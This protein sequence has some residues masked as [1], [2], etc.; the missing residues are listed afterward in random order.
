[1]VKNMKNEERE[2]EFLRGFAVL[3]AM[4]SMGR[5]VSP[6]VSLKAMLLQSVP[7]LTALIAPCIHIRRKAAPSE[8][9]FILGVFLMSNVVL[10]AVHLPSVVDM[11][12]WMMQVDMAFVTGLIVCSSSESLLQYTADVSRVQLAWFYFAAGFLK[13]TKYH[14]DW[15]LSCSSIFLSQIAIAWVPAQWMLP[16][17]VLL[18]IMKTAP[19]I[20]DILENGIA[21]LLFLGRSATLDVR[22]KKTTHV[23]WRTTS[24]HL[25]LLGA[26]AL[27]I[28][29]MIAPPPNS[30]ANFGAMCISC[31]FLCMPVAV[32]RA[33]SEVASAFQ[34]RSTTRNA[35]LV[36]AAV[37]IG[38]V[39]VTSAVHGDI[40]CII[41]NTTLTGFRALMMRAMHIERSG[42]VTLTESTTS[43]KTRAK[44]KRHTLQKNKRRWIDDARACSAVFFMSFAAFYAIGMPVLGL[45]DQGIS[46]MFGHLKVHAGSSHYILPTG[47][48]QRWLYDRSPLDASLGP[49]RDFAGGELRIEASTSDVLNGE[50]PWP[51]DRVQ[52][53]PLV[54]D[55]L[56]SLGH[57]TYM[58]SNNGGLRK[59]NMT[60]KKVCGEG[61]RSGLS[62]LGLGCSKSRPPVNGADGNFTR[63]T[64]PA[65]EI[66]TMLQ[67]M[68]RQKEAFRLEYTR[69]KGPVP[70]GIDAAEKWRIDGCGMR[71][72]LRED[73]RGVRECLSIDTC[74]STLEF[75]P[76]SPDA[77]INRILGRSTR[78]AADEIALLD[79]SPG[80]LASTL[81][82]SNPYP[83]LTWPDSD[84]VIYARLCGTKG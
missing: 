55:R 63:Y 23:G 20:T 29:I 12:W 78:C 36:Y 72:V 28:G 57:S 77:A 53:Y 61:E 11:D 17:A 49:L 65:L 56:R 79:T 74:L 16:D 18:T 51:R 13:L 45:A 83:I 41:A 25:G 22:E 27:H 10:V 4:Y 40:S 15:R 76:D 37:V 2:E 31:L 42:A 33:A 82:Y 59:N 5:W 44:T 24:L 47:L 81:L 43:V 50:V 30:I 26:I 70:W 8:L 6:P 9:R 34:P 68:R 7:V 35:V 80:L 38:I 46:H 66:R 60:A 54:R 3:L 64:L 73:G 21:V 62:A 1:M 32:S 69:I 58:F 48:L 52:P 71:V 84:E 19:F 75:L 67:E 39:A 14:S